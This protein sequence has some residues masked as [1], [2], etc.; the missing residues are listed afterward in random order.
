MKKKLWTAVVP[1]RGGRLCAQCKS[2]LAECIKRIQYDD[3]IW[4]KGTTTYVRMKMFNKKK[5]RRGIAFV[6]IES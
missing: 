4:C 5:F 3:L 2:S 6:F 1:F